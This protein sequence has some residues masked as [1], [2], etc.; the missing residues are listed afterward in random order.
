MPPPSTPTQAQAPPAHAPPAP[1]KTRT[2][3]TPHTHGRDPLAPRRLS[4]AFASHDPGGDTAAA[5]PQPIFLE[6]GDY[7]G[8]DYNGAAEPF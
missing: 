1:R 2:P 3:R 6:E 8:A 4:F 5:P 7:D